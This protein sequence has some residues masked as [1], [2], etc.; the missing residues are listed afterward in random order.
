MDKSQAHS[1][2][3]VLDANA[4]THWPPNITPPVAE[5]VSNGSGK[6]GEKR[7]LAM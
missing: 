2:V 6:N 5:I 7:M 1:I 3:S 4:I